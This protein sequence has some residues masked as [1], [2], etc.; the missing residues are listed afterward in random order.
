VP[1][2]Y[3]VNNKRLSNKVKRLIVSKSKKLNIKEIAQNACHRLQCKQHDVSKKA[4]LDSECLCFDDFSEQ[5][6]ELA[7]KLQTEKLLGKT[8]STCSWL[9]FNFVKN[10]FFCN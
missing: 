3:S 5:R 1:A 6:V 2:T 10:F 7:S 4:E 8:P 9:V